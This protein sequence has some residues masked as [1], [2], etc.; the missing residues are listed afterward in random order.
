MMRI[1]LLSGVIEFAYGKGLLQRPRIS[2][3]F[4]FPVFRSNGQVD[5]HSQS[6]VSGPGIIVG[7]K[8]SV[9][10]VIWLRQN[11]RPIN[12]TY[13]VKLKDPDNELIYWC[14][15]LKTLGLEKLNSHSVIPGLNRAARPSPLRHY[16]VDNPEAGGWNMVLLMELCDRIT[17]R[18]TLSTK[19][20]NYYG[21]DIQW[22][23][24]EELKDDFVF[25]S[26]KT[27][28]DDGLDE[29]SAKP[30]PVN[31]VMMAIYVVLTVGQL[32]ILT[33]EAVFNQSACRL[34][35]KPSVGYEF[36]YLYLPLSRFDLNNIANGAVRQNIS[37]GKV[38]NFAVVKSDDQMIL[39]FREKIQ[40]ILRG[41]NA[42]LKRT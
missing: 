16:F 9:G 23:S 41:L 17:S 7:R 42:I 30:F 32:G 38:H 8:G 35:A 11:F 33:Q 1:V 15:A 25:Y 5:T 29:S 3:Q 36:I 18:G 28:P 12:T 19:N 21:G 10:E 6:L 40:P 24:T 4:Q 27:I 39:K 37:V 31:T 2:G 26:E 13:Y 22:Y 34:V 20:D 14:Y